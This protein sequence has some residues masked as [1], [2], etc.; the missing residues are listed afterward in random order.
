M[1]IT[2]LTLKDYGDP[3]LNNYASFVEDGS[4]PIETRTWRTRHRGDLLIC[5]SKSS[6]SPNAGL[7]ICVVELWH[8]EPMIPEH[9]PFAR[10]DVYPNANSWFLRNHRKLSRKFAVTGSLNTFPVPVPVDVKFIPTGL[11][12]DFQTIAKSW[13]RDNIH[14]QLKLKW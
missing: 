11:F 3:A 8:I 2:A 9:V 14:G 12:D 10:C 4:K 1:I 13:E 7:A 5:C 6:K